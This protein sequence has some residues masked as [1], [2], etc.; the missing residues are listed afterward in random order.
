[1]VT[2]KCTKKDCANKD[3]EYN[4]GGNPETAQCGGCDTILIAKDLRND[5]EILPNT[6]Q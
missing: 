3:I 1:M 5:P 6:F 4:F 2:F